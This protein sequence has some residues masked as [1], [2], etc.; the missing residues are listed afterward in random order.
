MFQLEKN[1]GK[2]QGF[3]IRVCFGGAGTGSGGA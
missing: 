3:E 1:L 2:K